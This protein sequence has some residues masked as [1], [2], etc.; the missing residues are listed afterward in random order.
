MNR[1]KL[2]A[3]PAM[4]AAAI[5]LAAAGGAHGQFS[6]VFD[7]DPLSGPTLTPLDELGDLG[8]I[9]DIGLDPNNPG[10]DPEGGLLH[11]DIPEI[12]REEARDGNGFGDGGL[13]PIDL[14][15]DQVFPP[16]FEPFDPSSPDG[17]GVTPL[18]SES[19]ATSNVPSPGT[20]G[21]LA[22]GAISVGVRRRRR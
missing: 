11:V 22:A 10:V 17:F 3:V 8:G 14:D 16:I 13:P 18:V 9:L 20:I 19:G 4:I 12:D 15:P 6:S 7:I 21:L 2:Q 1:F 5:G